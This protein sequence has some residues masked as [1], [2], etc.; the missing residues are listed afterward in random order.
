VLDQVL[1]DKQR[2]FISDKARQKLAEWFLTDYNINNI[3]H[4]FWWFCADLFK[5]KREYTSQAVRLMDLIYQRFSREYITLNVPFK[6]DRRPSDNYMRVRPV[7]NIHTKTNHT[8]HIQI[9]ILLR[10]LTKVP[11]I[12]STINSTIASA[13]SYF[14]QQYHQ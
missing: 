2:I 10:L 4:L 5:D 8:K 14:S 12:K 7:G 3:T 11:S 6:T 9:K 13:T 1:E